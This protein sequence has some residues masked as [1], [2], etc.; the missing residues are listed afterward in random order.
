M[1]KDEGGQIDEESGNKVPVGG[2]KEGVRDDVPINIS[3]GEFVLPED[4]TRYIGLE[5][6]MQ[7]RQDA[8]MGL[9]RMEA[10]GLMGNSE[11][12]TMPDDLPFGM[13]DLI[14][15][16]V[17]EG[18]E[19]KKRANMNVGGMPQSR[20]LSQGQV[21]PT[22]LQP[23][24]KET[25]VDKI[26]EIVEYRNDAGNTL[27][28]VHINGVPLYPPPEGYSRYVAG[29]DVETD[30]ETDENIDAVNDIIN[31]ADAARYSDNDDDDPVQDVRT[32]FTKNGSWAGAELDGE[33][34]YMSEIRKIF[35]ASGMI[36]SGVGMAF[37]L[38]V[39]FMVRDQKRRALAVIDQRIEQ[40]RKA[41]RSDLVKE[42]NEIKAN[43]REKGS[44]VTG[45]LDN[46]VAGVSGTLNKI[47]GVKEEQ[48]ETAV[49]GVTNAVNDKEKNNIESTT[50]TSTPVTT[51]V[52][53]D[54]LSVEEQVKQYDTGFLDE[55]EYDGDTY[56]GSDL[57]DRINELEADLSASEA[58]GEM[59]QSGDL[60]D[61]ILDT[62]EGGLQKTEAQKEQVVMDEPVITPEAATAIEAEKEQIVMDQ[63]VYNPTPSEFVQG[64]TNYQETGD[65]LGSGTIISPTPEPE[66]V[67]TPE[68]TDLSAQTEEVFEGQ[69]GTKY[70]PAPAD[71]NSFAVTPEQVAYSTS[72]STAKDPYDPR[73]ILP[74][75]EQLIIPEP[76]T[77]PIQTSITQPELPE[78]DTSPIMP[79]P[80][81]DTVGVSERI[82]PISTT[83]PSVL[84]PLETPQIDTTQ[85]DLP[86]ALDPRGD[87]LTPPVV[88]AREPEQTTLESLEAPMPESTPAPAPSYA[89]MDMG[90]AGRGATVEPVATKE[91]FSE[92]FARN[93][94]EGKDTFTYEGKSYTTET[95]EEKDARTSD[96]QTDFNRD[97]KDT[98]G[99]TVSS[100]KNTNAV[101][102]TGSDVT[103]GQ[104][105]AGGQDAGDGFVWE[106][107][108]GTNVLTRKRVDTPSTSSS[109]SSN[110][111]G[112][113]GGGGSSGGDDTY[114][115][116]ASWK[117]KQMSISE[118]K[119][120]RKWHNKQSEVWQEGYDIW[121]K[122]VADNLVAK[123]DW[124][125]SVVKDIHRAFVKKD[126]TA[127]GLFGILVITSGVYP[128]GL[129]KVL[130]KK[131]STL[132]KNKVQG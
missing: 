19:D 52:I 89:T 132:Y 125:A 88:S 111:D 119:Q 46:I 61:T 20:A 17:G 82:P 81:S 123:S 113:G 57:V 104:I 23:E 32:Q 110:D 67:V 14:I 96:T 51:S 5:K 74:V 107:K 21:R 40:A 131:L 118:V 10:M 97:E 83:V 86:D 53:P 6:L 93:R 25:Y 56:G 106:K 63:P 108:E 84:T 103:I 54:P 48:K 4:V 70:V 87:Q 43:A 69:T 105:S 64:L 58:M 71:P 85:P 47:F 77:T 49:T 24:D 90:E 42:L 27:M 109:S 35:G 127:K 44:G 36:A 100:V 34:S 115:C 76:V 98:S 22:P 117:R 92:A 72:G 29:E 2:T 124:S 37:G 41:G 38:P 80:V 101:N 11:E 94:A 59:K 31:D 26:M 13:E 126:Y 122:W 9:K 128:T 16:E 95:K 112:G 129:Y 39:G 114:C 91:T 79:E 50:G 45:L 28:I 73:G 116:T 18:K 66:P 102:R 78:I 55:F 12:A 60:D 1:L 30:V 3:V 120:L 75:S 121:G 65:P 33:N 62:G 8:K 99:T 130:T 68:P 15:V 7:M